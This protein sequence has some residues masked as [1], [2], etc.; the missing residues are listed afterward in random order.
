MEAFL[1]M[2]F[3]ATAAIVADAIFNIYTNVRLLEM[4]EEEE[5]E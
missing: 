3:F 5:C 4:Y 2:M 1:I